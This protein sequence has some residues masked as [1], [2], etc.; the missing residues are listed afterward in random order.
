[1]CKW[2]MANHRV[3]INDLKTNCGKHFFSRPID[4]W[5]VL[6][7]GKLAAVG[8]VYSRKPLIDPVALFRVI[9]FV[10]YF[11]VLISG[12]GECYTDVLRWI[13]CF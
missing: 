3:S 11:H 5:F 2:R 12:L 1:M 9:L 10:S 7:L 13:S 4:P 8:G 6:T